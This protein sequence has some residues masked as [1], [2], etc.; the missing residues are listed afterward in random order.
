MYERI[1]NF[2]EDKDL[3]QTEI[4]DYLHVSQSMYSAYELG[5]T[6]IPLE[7]LIKLADLYKTSLDYL[8][9][10]TDEPTPYPPKKKAP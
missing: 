3:N 9:G 8:V 6:P 1:R 4:A 2:R 10:R 7:A 5:K